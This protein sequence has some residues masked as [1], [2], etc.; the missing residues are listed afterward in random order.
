MASTFPK[1]FGL[2]LFPQFEVLDIT[3][4]IEALNCLARLPDFKGMKLSIISQTLEPL[5][6]GPVAPNTA[7][8]DFIGVQQWIPT[9]TYATAPP[10]DVLLVPGGLG[11]NGDVDD[12]VAFIRHT[13]HGRDGQKPLEYLISV[14]NGGA[15]LARAGV[16][17]GKTVTTSKLDWDNV[18]ALGRKTHWIAKARWMA[19]GNVW[20]TSGVSAGLDG[21]IAWMETLLPREVVARILVIMEYNR[22]ESAED[23][24]FAAMNGCKDVLPQ[25]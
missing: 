2:L 17:D 21:V 15:L 13:Y 12:A 1:S 22:V 18:T 23:D 3:G 4:P 19:S 11:V 14:C 10:L 16:L 8:R 6:P 24:P 9:H 5:N 25:E 20:T 7:G